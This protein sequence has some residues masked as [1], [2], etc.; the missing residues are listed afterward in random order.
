[1]GGTAA[2]PVDAHQ[3]EHGPH[4]SSAVLF[5]GV[6]LLVGIVTR[7]LMQSVPVPY[8]A[9]LLVWGIL[10]GVA[11]SS[12]A[13]WEHMAHA[14]EL[15]KSM[16][17]ALLLLVFLPVL[18][19]AS[20][21][22]LD[23]HTFKQCFGQVLVLAGP[24]VVIGTALIG[25][26]MKYMFPYDWDWPKSLMFGAMMS[27]TDPVAVV[28]LLKEVGASQKLGTVIEGE[29]LFNDGTAYVV[30]LLFKEMVGGAS[31]TTISSVGFFC[32]MALG[33][34]AVGILFGIAATYWLALV[35]NDAI[36]EISITLVTTY[37][38]FYVAEDLFAVSGVLAVVV[39]G[40]VMSAM[41]SNRISPE[42]HEPMHVFWEMLEYL[43]NT[44]IF[45]YSGLV[46]AVEIYAS[47]GEA[48]EKAHIKAEDW[49]YSV[50]LFILLQVVRGITV[51]VLYPGLKRMG[52]GLTWREGVV[53]VWGGLRGAVGLALALIVKLDSNITDKR[54]QALVVFHMGLMAAATLLVNGTSI[55]L[56]LRV[57][58]VTNPTP[59][60]LEVLLHV[61]KEVE[62]YGETHLAHLKH[63]NLLG[64][65]DWD[66]V[67]K[68]TKMDV[69]TIIPS[70]AV[71]TQ[72]V[73]A[74][75]PSQ[76]ASAALIKDC[77]ERESTRLKIKRSIT[78]LV[79]RKTSM[80]PNKE[81]AVVVTR[82]MIQ[83]DMRA[84]LL[85]AVKATYGE[86][87]E[88]GYIGINAIGDLKESADRALDR[89]MQ[90]LSDW[91]FVEKL[92]KMPKW[93]RYMQQSSQKR[94][95]RME[96]MAQT[97]LFNTI[98][99]SVVLSTSFVFAHREAERGL[100]QYIEVT[101]DEEE[102]RF[103]DNRAA[104]HKM[105]YNVS[106]EVCNESQKLCQKA[107][108]FTRGMSR[109]FPEIVRAIKTKQASR[110]V[111]MHKRRFMD[112]LAKAGLIEQ[113]EW[114]QLVTLLKKA[115]KQLIYTPP[116]LELPDS[117]S[118]LR[119][120]SLF[121][122]IDDETFNLSIWPLATHCVYDEGQAIFSV[123]QESTHVSMVVR[124]AVH[125]KE[126]GREG[127][128]EEGM[129]AII[130]ITE[131]LTNQVRTRDL[132]A[133]TFVEVYQIEADD[134]RELIQLHEG[135][136][137]RAWQMAGVS[138][139]HQIGVPE[140]RYLDHSELHKIFRN[141]SLENVPV[142]NR[143]QII[144]D[145][146]LLQGVLELT[147]PE[148]EEQN[149]L[150]EGPAML[151]ADPAF[152]TCISNVKLLT[153]PDN[154]STSAQREGDVKA[155]LMLKGTSYRDKRI[156]RSQSIFRT[157]V[158]GEYMA[159]GDPYAAKRRQS[160]YRPHIMTDMSEVP[161]TFQR[162]GSDLAAQPS[163]PFRR[164]VSSI[165]SLG[166]GFSKS[167]KEQRDAPRWDA[168]SLDME[169]P[170]FM[171]PS[172]PGQMFTQSSIASTTI[173]ENEALIPP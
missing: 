31:R 50:V 1:M 125:V 65:P 21:N 56:I 164:R 58:G 160:S 120:H 100:R 132:N 61:V 11:D 79:K 73:E 122:D 14:I 133:A 110:T 140:V 23:F 54:F 84:R 49:G 101:G 74:S 169:S 59:A 108:Q 7:N 25:C 28:A 135:L 172:I 107:I 147:M 92:C 146:L 72:V 170:P 161:D 48:G 155:M 153:L 157:T 30:F 24:G 5:V 150:F 51:L 173:E 97:H 43:A 82:E 42:V 86:G 162:D 44:L 71:C 60:K 134:M 141:T 32:Q 113:K 45:V 38:T 20:A 145:T 29:S 62:Q 17:P 121:S 66:R 104:V 144:A 138:L 105:K 22:S 57:L 94:F 2:E 114:R 171:E 163:M 3:V 130:G 4:P 119:A 123:G 75:H 40:V 78:E 41:A 39:L 167:V 95:P 137:M 89:L 9:L 27:A 63:D 126:E 168:S 131:I 109:A 166:Y 118:L 33:G 15:W 70:H 127:L 55:P 90:P 52:Y 151:T 149:V 158:A 85:E 34:P 36:V 77:L 91:D 116:R 81:S 47:G 80:D 143:I 87:F 13:D 19:Y 68:L 148:A 93:M 159:A 139:A 8:T 16:D 154:W 12:F 6:V 142:G 53:M 111:L 152:F 18:I 88:K 46:I 67:M 96:K 76:D 129:G 83:T 69:S 103:D 165:R 37:L 26:A 35:F 98:E 102:D 10:M 117:K 124:G 64:N 115:L 156:Q 136:E 106:E 128:R 112:R 99:Y